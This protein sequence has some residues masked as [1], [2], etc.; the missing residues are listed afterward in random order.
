[1]PRCAR[2]Q[3]ETNTYHIFIRGVGRQLIFEDDQD[4]EMFLELIERFMGDDGKLY[5]WVLMDNHVHMIIGDDMKDLSSFMRRLETSYSGYFNKRYDR[6]GHLFQGRFGSEG[7]EDDRQLL[8][9]IRYVHQNP[10]KA[11]ISDSCDYKWSSYREYIDSSE[12]MPTLCDTAFILA[13]FDEPS[14]FKKF[15]SEE[16]TKSLMDL[17]GTDR[18]YERISDSQALRILTQTLGDEWVNLLKDCS[19][20]ERNESLRALKEAGLSIRQI[21]RLT[22]I[23]RGIIQRS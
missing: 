1:M 7:I 19:K 12:N 21:E 15:H 14:Q 10:V 4:R 3:V 5:A 6:V 8:A 18:R 11:G 9:A 2:K 17:G 16:E 13:I 22:G 20:E 23:G